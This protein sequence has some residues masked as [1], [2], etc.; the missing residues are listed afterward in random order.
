MKI[1]IGT[2]REENRRYDIWLSTHPYWWVEVLVYYDQD[3][4]WM[5][6]LGIPIENGKVKRPT[7]T[8]TPAI[9][10]YIDGLLARLWDIR[11]FL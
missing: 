9:E 1:K 2:Y 5:C 10:D 7:P 3:E 4:H 8:I 6:S 11:L